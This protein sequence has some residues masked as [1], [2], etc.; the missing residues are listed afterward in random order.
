[1]VLRILDGDSCFS[2]DRRSWALRLPYFL[3]FCERLGIDRMIVIDNG[4]TDGSAKILDAYPF[5]TR[6]YTTKPFREHKTIWRETLANQF[7]AHR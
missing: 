2:I 5:V 4:S 3:K 6:F 7:F 1:V